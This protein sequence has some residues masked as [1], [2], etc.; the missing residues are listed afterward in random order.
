[1]NKTLA[2]LAGAACLLLTTAA[3]ATQYKLDFTVSNFTN[4]FVTLERVPIAGSIV[5][6]AD[7][8]GAAVTSIDAVDLA[9]DGHVYTPGEIGAELWGSHYAFGGKAYDI[10]G[11]QALTDDF[12]IYVN[13]AA[14]D[15][16]FATSQSYLY[17][18]RD[19]VATYSEPA[20]AGDVPEPGS[21]ALLLA[22][23]GALGMLSRP[24]R[25]RG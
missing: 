11:V 12:Y 13:G 7:A 21:L 17:F 16:Q 3:Q 14:N 8:L 5:F 24:R 2:A 15:F 20:P 1:M 19:I 6:S 10:G 23:A 4:N 25:R 18:G 9:I 22:G